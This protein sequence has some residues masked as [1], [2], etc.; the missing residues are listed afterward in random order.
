MKRFVLVLVV[1]SAM[2]FKSV[3]ARAQKTEFWMNNSA[4]SV[5]SFMAHKDKIDVISPTCTSSTRR[6]W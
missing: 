1:G 5:N 3:V 4:A 2:L 6:A